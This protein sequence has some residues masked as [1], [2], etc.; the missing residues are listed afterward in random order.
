MNC[1]ATDPS[2][3]PE[4]TR[5]TEP[6]RTS[7]TA[8]SPGTLVSSRKGSRSRVH[9]LGRWPSRIRSG[10]VSR[11]PRSSRST[12]VPSQSVRGKAPM[13]MNIALAGTRSTLFVS[14]QSTEISSRCVCPQLNVRRFF[15]LVNQI[16]RHGTGE[17]IASHKNDDPIRVSRKIHGGLTCRIRASHY[18][19]GFA[20]ARERFGGTAAIV[21]ACPLQS[22]D[23]RS[24]ES[25]PLYT[26]R[27]QQR[28]A[29]DL[30]PIR[31]LNNPVGAFSAGAGRFQRRQN[32]HSKTH[33]LGDCAPSQVV[34]TEPG[35]KSQIILDARTH[36][37]LASRRFALDHHRMQTFRSSVNR[38]R[39]AR[40]TAA[41]NRE[42]V[43]VG[44]RACAQPNLLGDICWHALQKFCP[45]GKKYDGK[46][47]G[48]R[49]Q[50]LHQTL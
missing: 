43:E 39:Q 50:S 16:L 5:F 6:C 42:I 37:C 14:E 3:T 23:S 44:L 35:G 7:P 32:L 47:G 30:V 49:S 9:P 33:R 46:I 36:S 25:P 41:D 34:P 12:K 22:I 19:D 1:T 45:V 18:V 4:A 8:N 27:D 10:P 20:L 13:K 26:G 21:D 11:K 31:Q 15:D 24:F 38:G 48:L 29:G 40:G 17:R 28:V 2:P